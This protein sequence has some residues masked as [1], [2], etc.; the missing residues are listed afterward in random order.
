MQEKEL[1]Y[2][3]EDNGDMSCV[4]ETIH[5]ATLIIEGY[6]LDWEPDKVEEIFFT[7]TPVYMTETEY[8]ALGDA[9]F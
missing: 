6:T 4:C 2:R 5:E 3:L 9:Q 8:N 1:Y 7:I